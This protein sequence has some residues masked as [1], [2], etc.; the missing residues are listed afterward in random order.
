MEKFRDGE[1][2]RLQKIVA[3]GKVTGAELLKSDTIDKLQAKVALCE[4]Q[5]TCL[6]VRLSYLIAMFCENMMTCACRS[7]WLALL[8]PGC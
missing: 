8:C 4:A 7:C 5:Q 1:V 3:S 6:K 2:A